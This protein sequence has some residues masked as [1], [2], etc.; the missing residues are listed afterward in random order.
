MDCGDHLAGVLNGISG[1]ELEYSQ[2]GFLRNF[3]VP[4]LPH[5]F[6]ALFLFLEK[7]AFTG[8]IATV[9]L[10][11]NVFPDCLHCFAGNDLCADCRL[12]CHIILLAG[13]EFLE[14]LTEFPAEIIGIVTCNEGRQCIHYFPVKQDVEFDKV[15]ILV[16]DRVVIK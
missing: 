3:H 12:Y 8:D 7:L 13:D 10:G 5:S 1:I 15:G 9:T 14:L 6:L 16:T 11:S 4:D 2:E